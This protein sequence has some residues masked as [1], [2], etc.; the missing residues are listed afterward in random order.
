MKKLSMLVIV[1]LVLVSGILT[2]ALAEQKIGFVYSDRI[3][4]EYKE[5][6][7]AQSKLDVEARKLQ[8]QYQGMIVKLDSLKKSYDQ[9]KMMMSESRRQEK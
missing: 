8:D 2:T 4:A 1:S 6:Q 7:E 3:L 9:Q 5:A